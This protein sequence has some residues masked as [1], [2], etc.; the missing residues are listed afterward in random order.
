MS[1]VTVIKPNLLAIQAPELLRGL[2]GWLMWRYEQP[3]DPKAKPR[4]VPYY[5][6]GA[7]RTGTQGSPEDRQQLTTFEAAKAAA[8]R[9]GFD[10][11]GLALMPEWGVCA[12]DFDHCVSSAGLPHEV[13]DIVAATYAEYSPSGEGVRA[14]VRGNF[15]NRKDNTPGQW[16]FETFSTKGFVTFTG[17]RLELVEMLGNDDVVADAPEAVRR[18]CSQRFHQVDA[19]DEPDTGARPP[20]GLPPTVLREALDALPDDLHYDDWVKVG[21][22]V[23]H[24][25][26][27][28]GFDVWDEWSARSSKYGGPEYG[29][30]RWDSFGRS[31]RQVTAAWLVHQANLHG[32]RINLAE[33][34]SADFEAI[35]PDSERKRRFRIEPL[36]VFLQRPAPS[37]IVKGVI[38]EGDLIVMFGES[39]SGKSFQAL[40]LGMA[41]ARGL[42]W[43]G[44]RVRQGRVTYI[45]A[46]GA[47]GFRNRVAAYCREHGVEP[48]D[49]PLQVIPDAPNLLLREDALDIAADIVGAGGADLIIVDTFAQVT[50][51]ANENAAEDMGKALSHCRGLKRATGAPV[52][53]VHHSGKDQA[54]GARGWSGLKAAAD[55]ELEVLRTPGGRYMRT[56]KQKDGAD[57][58]EW[59]FDLKVVSLGFDS[60]GDEITSCVSVEAAVPVVQRVGPGRQLGAVEQVVVDVISEIAGAQTTG[61]EIN[62]V[63]K[64]AS[65]RLPEPTDGKRDQRKAY[66]RRA[67]NSLCKGD[68]SPYFLEDDGTISL[69]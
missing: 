3:P 66:V 50:P 41:I 20:L 28:A 62:E 45:A 5:T 9:R 4:K 57:G 7:R 31:T 64:L 68:E 49:V 11:V 37:W 33:L 59:G 63:L 69:G 21:M 13:Q 46:E 25:T 29:R 42:E 34:V 23:H 6:T 10:G 18:L 27:G 65:S 44:R 39:G 32:A 15:G 26:G 8:A 1:T 40:D 48:A 55:A 54:R 52:L 24:E 47:G 38:P 14:F 16:G 56:S 2:P 12:L 53:L 58:L 19:F 35:K 60:D 51:G 43:R 36:D 61:I 30:A 17:N 22:A 67:L